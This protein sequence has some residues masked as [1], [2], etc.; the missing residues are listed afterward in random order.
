MQTKYKLI[1]NILALPV[2]DRAYIID[3]LIKA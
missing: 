3:S 2:E 1:E